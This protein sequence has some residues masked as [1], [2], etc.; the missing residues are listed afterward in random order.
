MLSQK[1]CQD[2]ADY[3]RRL[4][5]IARSPMARQTWLKAEEF[6]RERAEKAARFMTPKREDAA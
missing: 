4:S 5:D 3:C 6:W 1:E 2:R